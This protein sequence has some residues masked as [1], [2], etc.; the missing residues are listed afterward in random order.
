MAPELMPSLKETFCRRARSQPA[1]DLKQGGVIVSKHA[2]ERQVHK[3]DNLITERDIDPDF[4]LFTEASFPGGLEDKAQRDAIEHA[5]PKE[6][7]SGKP[8]SDQG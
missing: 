6:T 4:G 5:L 7:P 8:A 2:E 1:Q 3:P